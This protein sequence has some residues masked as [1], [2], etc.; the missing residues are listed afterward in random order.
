MKV[1]YSP[2]AIAQLNEIFAYIAKDNPM[3]AHAVI[4]RIESVAAKLADFPHMGYATDNG[5]FRVMNVERYPYL[6]FYA[7]L[8]ER[9][10]VRI[11]RIRHAAR[12]R[13]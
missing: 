1:T 6:V 3:A 13:P 12:Q 4:A 7:V 2:R 5:D 8:P 10:E 11:V 9:D